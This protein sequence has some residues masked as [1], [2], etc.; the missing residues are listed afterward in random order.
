MW[1]PVGVTNFCG[2]N[3]KTHKRNCNLEIM[4]YG[5][6]MGGKTHMDKFKKKWFGPFR[7]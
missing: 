6:P 3:I 7:V 5:F 4:F 1:E 2:V